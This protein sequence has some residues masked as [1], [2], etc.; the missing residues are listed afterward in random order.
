MSGMVCKCWCLFRSSKFCLVPTTDVTTLRYM[1]IHT[2]YACTV[3]H[4]SGVWELLQSSAQLP[5]R[6]VDREELSAG[7]TAV[8][9]WGILLKMD[10]VACRQ[11]LSAHVC[12]HP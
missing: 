5:S 3:Y 12:I 7:W 6:V 11:F 4:G 8:E 9:S 1:H 10:V 2:E